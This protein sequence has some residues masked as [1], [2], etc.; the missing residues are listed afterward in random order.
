MSENG[1]NRK[2]RS[3]DY[4]CQNEGCEYGKGHKFRAA[5]EDWFEE[6]GLDTP[7]NCPECR[8]WFEEQEEIG[9]ITATCHLCGYTW[10]IH[11]AYRIIYHKRIGNWDDYWLENESSMI[12][13]KCEEFPSR[14]RKLM[15]RKAERGARNTGKEERAKKRQGKTTYENIEVEKELFKIARKKGIRPVHRYN[16]PKDPA[17]YASIKEKSGRTALDHIMKAGHEWTAKIGTETPYSVLNIAHRIAT[18]TESHILEFKVGN[19]VMKYDTHQHVCVMIIG[20]KNSLT[21]NR[22]F[23]AYS[24][25]LDDV[26][27]KIEGKDWT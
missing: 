5:S 13:R 4:E 24:K 6:R 1:E 22:I 9:P 12:C 10:P 23:T 14:R 19:R 15:S 26:K 20:D 21:K 18:S 27:E 11:F 3:Q 16:V 7:R 17:Y 2:S 25:E 8:R